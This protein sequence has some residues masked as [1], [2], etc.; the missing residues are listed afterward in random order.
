MRFL[1]AILSL[2]LFLAI[3]GAQAPTLTLKGDVKEVEREKQIVIKEKVTCV[4]FTKP[5]VIQA[6]AGAGLYHW[7]YPP[8][9]KVIEKRDVLEVASAPRGPCEISC[10]VVTAKVVDGNVVFAET[11]VSVAFHVGGFEPPVPTEPLAKELHGL[12]VTDAGSDKAAN[13]VKLAAVYRSAATIANQKTGEAYLVAT[14]SQLADAVRATSKASL[15]ADV[16]PAVRRRCNEVVGESLAD[17]DP[18][19][20]LTIEARAKAAGLYGRIAGALEQLK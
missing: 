11:V 5:L 10:K 1:L 2:L 13:V 7:V 17:V 20:P 3:L 6:P 18:D 9:C 4:D 14:A 19:E 16:L 8:S 12:F 15:P